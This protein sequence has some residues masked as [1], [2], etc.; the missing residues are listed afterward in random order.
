M[1]L[2]DG[3]TLDLSATDAMIATILA[4]DAFAD[5]FDQ[6][7]TQLVGDPDALLGDPAKYSRLQQ[8]GIVL[9]FDALMRRV[10][11]HLPPDD[12]RLAHVRDA[13]EQIDKTAKAIRE[14][15]G[16]PEVV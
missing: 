14:R 3:S 13:I 11:P 10:K 7:Q 12:P 5:A 16:L 15:Y 6:T 9:L 4:V 1:K 8:V 2:H